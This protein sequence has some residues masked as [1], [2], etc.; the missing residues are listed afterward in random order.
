MGAAA[1]G[2]IGVLVDKPSPTEPMES[3]FV[4]E[5]DVTYNPLEYDIGDTFYTPGIM[6]D[7]KL[8][9][10]LIVGISGAQFPFDLFALES[11][12]SFAPSIGYEANVGFT[13]DFS[14]NTVAATNQYTPGDELNFK[15]EYADYTRTKE[16]VYVAVRNDC[17]HEGTYFPIRSFTTDFSLS[18]S[19]EFSWTIPYSDHLSMYLRE[20]SEDVDWQ[21]DRSSWTATAKL[22]SQPFLTIADTAPFKLYVNWHD[23]GY[24]VDDTRGM[25]IT[26]PVG[27]EKLTAASHY[28]FEWDSEHF[29]YFHREVGMEI[30]TIESI[31]NVDVKLFYY[32]CLTPYGMFCDAHF[33]FLTDEGVGTSNDGSESLYV[34]QCTQ[35]GHALSATSGANVHGL[36]VGKENSNVVARSAP[37]EVEAPA[38]CSDDEKKSMSV[39]V[40]DVYLKELADTFKTFQTHAVILDNSGWD[41]MDLYT[42]KQDFDGAYSWNEGFPLLNVC[43]SSCLVIELII[44]DSVLSADSKCIIWAGNVEDFL[45]SMTENEY[46]RFVLDSGDCEFLG[47]A[48]EGQDMFVDLKWTTASLCPVGQYLRDP[49]LFPKD[50]YTCSTNTYNDKRSQTECQQ[51][52]SGKVTIGDSTSHHDQASDCQGCASGSYYSSY[53]AG[54]IDSYSCYPCDS[55]EY[56]DAG[57]MECLSCPEGK[58]TPASEEPSD[59]AGIESCQLCPKGKHVDANFWPMSYFDPDECEVCAKGKYSN[60][61]NAQHCSECPN[62]KTTPDGTDAADHDD[63]SD[64]ATC[65]AGSFQSGDKCVVCATNKWSDAGATECTGCAAGTVTSA[66]TTFEEHAGEAACAGC[67]AGKQVKDGAWIWGDSGC[68]ICEVGKYSTELNSEECTSCPDGYITQG[69]TASDFD[70]LA[71][72]LRCPAGTYHSDDACIV[73]DTNEYSDPAASECTACPSGSVTADNGGHAEHAGIEACFG[74]PAGTRVKESFWVWGDDGCELCEVGKYSTDLNSAECTWCPTGRTQGTV[75]DPAPSNFD[76]L[77]DCYYCPAGSYRDKSDGA[78]CRGCVTNTYSNLAEDE[79]TQCPSNTVTSDLGGI[80]EHANIEACGG[81]APG[82]KVL[83]A[84][85]GDNSCTVCEAGKYSTEI[86]SEDCT[87]CPEGKMSFGDTAAKHDSTDSCV[88]CVAGSYENGNEC[89]MCGT[90]TYS[91]SGATECTAC[92]AAKYTTD[93]GGISEH[94]GI[95]AC[96]G[97]IPGKFIAGGGV[98]G[99]DVH[100]EVCGQN[101]YSDVYDA[102]ECTFCQDTVI[103]GTSYL[104]HNSASDCQAC[105]P[106][107]HYYDPFGTGF[108]YCKDDE[109]LLSSNTLRADNAE[110][111]SD[112]S[113]QLSKMPTDEC[114]KLFYGM[115]AS[116][117]LIE[118]KFKWSPWGASMH[119]SEFK[120]SLWED[121]DGQLE[122]DFGTIKS[123]QHFYNCSTPDPDMDTLSPTLSPSKAPSLAPTKAP[124]TSAPTKD[125]ATR[126]PTVAPTK[127]PTMAPTT[128]PTKAPTVPATPIPTVAPTPAATEAPTAKEVSQI[129]VDVSVPSAVQISIGDTQAVPDEDANKS[130]F[131]A[132]VAIMEEA[133]F[134]S[135]TRTASDPPPSTLRVVITKING[136]AV[137]LEAGRRSLSTNVDIEFEIK[138]EHSCTDCTAETVALAVEKDF[139]AITTNVVEAAESGE[140]AGTIKGVC[141]ERLAEMDEEDKELFTAIGNEVQVQTGAVVVPEELGEEMK[142]VVEEVI[143]EIVDP[144]EE[145]PVTGAPSPT[146][147]TTK[148]PT[149]GDGGDAV[150]EDEDKKNAK[151]ATMFGVPTKQLM[152]YGT[153][154][155]IGVGVLLL[156]V[157]TKGARRSS[158]R[159]EADRLESEFG[160]PEKNPMQSFDKL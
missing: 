36:V 14:F 34:K 100:C 157:F 27:G 121:E 53:T 97:C 67:A 54:V 125:G 41:N 31:E 84:V 105:A 136:K 93:E 74:C 115:E 139:E 122:M 153:G 50:C 22:A 106:G 148:A 73:C 16:V 118:F 160:S 5:I 123:D 90:N 119:G 101:Q 35:D 38:V 75:T 151:D 48:P 159:Q 133:L 20:E 79:C 33:T 144:V 24:L 109:R 65:P 18:G 103:T 30:G 86:N 55:N 57:A 156:V 137:H 71:D 91:D 88:K 68:E 15:L 152:M 17:W 76:E 110:E 145:P 66:G 149:A 155:I 108:N 81:C 129:T 23:D 13:G 126:M 40:G 58:F 150:P 99:G 21:C 124:T 11:M 138:W 104:D 8:E 132:F 49:V 19:H 85:F 131:D 142:E 37:F 128:S 47:E 45:T 51:C 98:F 10:R 28:S 72:C 9:P 44:N 158:R 62:G 96:A 12:I 46:K 80:A 89:T 60:G 70:E 7:V 117:G 140:M 63:V 83:S 107:K 134:K 154:C 61:E 120:L 1:S 42:T 82:T 113:R 64:C 135:V 69:E 141:D 4:T 39:I 56:S 52:E 3:S 143:E 146:P 114:D 29:T 147:A 130:Q 43:S 102:T 25:G 6:F 78:I 127:S 95:S 92:P 77:D 87:Q 112:D 2:K 94:A 116:A 32:D 59:H 111:E 26:A